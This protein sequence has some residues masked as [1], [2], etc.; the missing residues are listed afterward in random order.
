MRRLPETEAAVVHELKA[1]LDA[2]MVDTGA[3]RL[4]AGAEGRWDER[5]NTSLV[6]ATGDLAALRIELDAYAE[7]EPEPDQLRM[8]EAA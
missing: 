8:D 1:L 6:R 4:Y 5:R 7:R 2:T 3:R